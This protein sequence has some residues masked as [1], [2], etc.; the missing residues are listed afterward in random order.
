MVDSS[1]GVPHELVFSNNLLCY[2]H[3]DTTVPDYSIR[4]VLRDAKTGNILREFPNVKGV[5][6]SPDGKTLATA[7][8]NLVKLWDISQFAEK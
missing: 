7:S 8:G 1:S 5:M 3:Q 4:A 6:L 2:T